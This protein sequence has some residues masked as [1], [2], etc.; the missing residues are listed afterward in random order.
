MKTKLYRQQKLPGQVRRAF[1]LIELL[2]VIA[3]IAILAAMLLPALAGAKRKAKDINCTSN[4]KQFVLALNIYNTDYAALI[5]NADPNSTMVGALWMPRLET[6]YNISI[7][8]RCC[9][10]TPPVVPGTSWV[11]K[12]PKDT[13]G[14]FAC[15]GTAVNTWSMLPYGPDMQSGYG[16]NNWITSGFSSPY[17]PNRASYFQK[18]S[19][20][21]NPSS[22]PYFADSSYAVFGCYTSDTLPTD[23]LN[24][25]GPSQYGLGR[26]AIARHGVP[27]APQ[28]VDPSGPVPGRINLGLTDGHVESSKLDKLLFGY[29][30]S[31]SWPN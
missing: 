11:C 18:Q 28:S 21:M 25:S 20:I 9:P 17:D 3:I 10:F 22:T 15:F 12:N 19:A 26:I 7:T 14:A 1:T 13:S 30:W 31:K 29:S 16:I 24:G 27:S 6:N 23:L 2:V 5:S 8:A 4:L